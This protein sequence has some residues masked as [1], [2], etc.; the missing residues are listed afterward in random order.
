[1]FNLKVSFYKQASLFMCLTLFS[2]FSS[3]QTSDSKSLIVHKID[4]I[5]QGHVNDSKIPGAVIQIKRGDKVVYKQA[6]GYAQKFNYAHEPLA[7]PDKMTTE[8][9]F[10]I[11]SLTKVV[12]TTTSI[13]L[14]VDRGLIKINDPVSK[15][16][17]AFS[18]PDKAGITVIRHLLNAYCR[19]LRVVPL[20]FTVLQINRKPLN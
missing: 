17:K 5:L 11:A 10:D 8:D 20:F 4:S 19:P 18:A 16:I 3:G 15:Y 7:V 6:Y 13:M 9:M 1:M 12:G 2:T 14:L